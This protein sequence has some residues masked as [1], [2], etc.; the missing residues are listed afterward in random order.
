MHRIIV[1]GKTVAMIEEPWYV[2]VK[3]STGAWIHCKPAEAEAISLRGTLYNLP[4]KTTIADAPEAL[5]VPVDAIDEIYRGGIE[6]YNN[7]IAEIEDAL[8]D[9]DAETVVTND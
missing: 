4:G 8:C 6:V 5:V 7:K 2:K 3:P 1:E 9:I